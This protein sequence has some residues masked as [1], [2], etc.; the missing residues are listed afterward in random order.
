[1]YEGAKQRSV[2]V[3][4]NGEGRAEEEEG[5]ERWWKL[6]DVLEDVQVGKYGRDWRR[7]VKD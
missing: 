3:E 5:V 6:Q 7:W 2:I 1:M 4:E